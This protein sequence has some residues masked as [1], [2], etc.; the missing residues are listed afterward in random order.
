[1]VVVVLMLVVKV[2]VMMKV[3]TI[4]AVVFVGW[5]MV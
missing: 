3:S 1:M 2:L 4:K 5:L